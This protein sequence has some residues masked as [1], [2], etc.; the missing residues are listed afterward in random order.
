MKGGFII[1]RALEMGEVALN[2]TKSLFPIEKIS[3]YFTL[4][5]STKLILNL[6]V[7]LIVYLLYRITKR[8]VSKRL[9]KISK[10]A[11]VAT[12]S[13]GL[14]YLFY[15]TVVLFVLHFFGI[16]LSAVWGAAGI[17]G[18]AIGFAA[19]TTISN[20]I[21]GIFVVTE[22]SLK[23]GDFIEIDGI[24]GIVD[25]ISF[26]SVR[27]HTLDNQYVRI[28]N[29]IIINRILKNYS[30]FEYRRYQFEFSIDYASNLDKVVDVISQV[31]AK[32]ESVICDDERYLPTLYFSSLAASGI[33][34]TLNVWCKGS[35][36]SKTKSDVCKN[37][38]MACREQKIEIPFNRLDVNLIK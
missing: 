2:E 34:L 31:P 26:L 9:T 30:T 22:K 3:S 35:D 13:R 37:V 21:S 19:Q 36:F 25:T 24:S 18:V 1:G 28:P 27:I 5:K 6:S 7:L 32:C 10:P 14:S 17:A 16:K 12:V 33:V 8:F 38:I 11:T 15:I 4:E 20:V 29:S 23:T